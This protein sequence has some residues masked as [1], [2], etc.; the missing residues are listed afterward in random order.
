MACATGVQL[1]VS[2]EPPLAPGS[3]AVICGLPL[4]PHVDAGATENVRVSEVSD[5]QPWPPWTTTYHLLT[6]LPAFTDSEVPLVDPASVS[7]PSVSTQ[8]SYPDAEL[9]AVQDNATGER[10]VAPF[11]GERRVGAFAGQV[12]GGTTIAVET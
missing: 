1:M 5:V 12:G 7:R 4:L 6:P 10:T 2:G 8:T 3:G 11:A 9:T